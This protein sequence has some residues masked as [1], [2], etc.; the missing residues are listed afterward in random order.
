MQLIDGKTISEQIKQE[1]SAEVAEIVANEENAR[2]W[3]PS[4]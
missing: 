3:P 4:W 2:I 1:I